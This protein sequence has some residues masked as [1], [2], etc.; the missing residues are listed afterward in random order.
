[1]YKYGRLI[2]REYI[3]VYRCG[4]NALDDS[5]YPVEDSYSVSKPNKRCDVKA[6]S[7]HAHY[8]WDHPTMRYM[9]IYIPDA[10]VMFVMMDI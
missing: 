10:Y 7:I 6:L 2:V 3:Y 5:R 9:W 4:M 1:M 8:F